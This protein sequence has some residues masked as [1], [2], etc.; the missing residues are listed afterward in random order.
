M[1][2]FGISPGFLATG[3]SGMGS[4]FMRNIGAGDPSTG[5]DFIRDV[6]EGKRDE[7]AGKIINR[8]GVQPR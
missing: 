5:G 8:D 7:D 1:K 3:L 6:V 2:V 4:E